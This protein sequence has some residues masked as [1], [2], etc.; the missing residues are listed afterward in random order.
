MADKVPVGGGA[1]AATV[2]DAPAGLAAPGDGL[3][4]PAEALDELAGDG[5]AAP[6]VTVDGDCVGAAAG[7]GS[8]GAAAG[9]DEHAATRIIQA[10]S[11]GRAWKGRR[12]TGERFMIFLLRL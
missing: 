5:L 11:L 9:G 4:A 6:A 3:D 10:M 12:R 8:L 2:F 1:A 7:M